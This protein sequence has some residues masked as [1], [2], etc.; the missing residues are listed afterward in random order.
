MESWFL[1]LIPPS[2]FSRLST[3]NFYWLIDCV[4][5]MFSFRQFST[6]ALPQIH[7]S[8]KAGLELVVVP[9]FLFMIYFLRQA[10]P[11]NPWLSLIL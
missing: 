9:L 6:W 10:L 7:Y 2:P 11:V 1:G 5:W 3:P 8:L 4:E